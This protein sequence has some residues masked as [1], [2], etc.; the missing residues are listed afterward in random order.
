MILK[1]INYEI[2]EKIE[3]IM[4]LKNTNQDCWIDE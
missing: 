4:I 3:M 1:N 2:I